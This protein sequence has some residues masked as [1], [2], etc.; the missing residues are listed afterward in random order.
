MI[1]GSS[2]AIDVEV[3]GN[4]REMG[5]KKSRWKHRPDENELQAQ[6]TR[7]LGNTRMIESNFWT[8]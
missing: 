8:T 5:L 1:I 6:D 3:L 2:W 4:D 7:E